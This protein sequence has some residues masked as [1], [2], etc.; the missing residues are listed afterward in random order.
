VLRVPVVIAGV[1]CHAAAFAQASPPAS[2][3]PATPPVATTGTPPV[4]PVPVAPPVPAAPPAAPTGE[5]NVWIHDEQ[6]TILIDG[7]VRGQGTFRG[8]L[9]A[10][11]HQLRVTRDG[12]ETHESW[13]EIQAGQAHSE[14]IS[15]QQ[16]VAPVSVASTEAAR[17]LD[18][19]YGGI[20]LLG[21]LEP[22]GSGTTLD[23]A[24]DTTGATSCSVGT[25]LGAGLSGYVGWLF[26]PLGLEIALLGSAHVD[27]PVA[28]FDGEQG[29]EINP[30]VAAPQR[31]EKF[32]IGRFGGGA[33]IR[34]RLW[35]SVSSVRFTVA[36]GPGFVYRTLAFRRETEAADGFTSRVAESD[37]D[38]V[39]PLLS[40]ELG[41]EFALSRS[42]GFSVGVVSWFEHAGDDA[43]SSAR[44]DGTLFLDEDTPPLAQATPAYDLTSGPQWFI[45]PYL[46]V[47]FGP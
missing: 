44:N 36:A 25:S 5:L 33:A 23:N 20:R 27:R 32:T 6:G 41:A 28:E 16:R 18:G 4:P 2:P 34:G 47:A 45:G 26:E 14:S 1:A 24:C 13:V 8:N 17:N 38:Y 10:G 37:I 39:S 9:P 40:V 29:S 3:N 35:H 42:L 19:I 21:A 11:R 12:F 43:K 7:E 22:T 15:L 31:D 46:G 30:V